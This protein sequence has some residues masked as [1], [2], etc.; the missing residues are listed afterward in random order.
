[1]G[2]ETFGETGLPCSCF[3]RACNSSVGATS[4]NASFLIVRALGFFVFFFFIRTG[5]AFE[6][7]SLLLE[8]FL[9][10]AVAPLYSRHDDGIMYRVYLFFFF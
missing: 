3:C 6:S 2:K 7:L 9:F 8:M 4:S 10:L 1:M 5:W